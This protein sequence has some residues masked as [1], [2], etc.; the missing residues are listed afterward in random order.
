MDPMASIKVL[1]LYFIL[2]FAISALVLDIIDNSLSSHHDY[3]NIL[4]CLE[5]EILNINFARSSHFPSIM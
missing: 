5:L 2:W 4:H 3:Q 1:L